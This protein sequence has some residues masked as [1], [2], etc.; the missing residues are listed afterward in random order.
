MSEI[1]KI[2][3]DV[4]QE[5]KRVIV[6]GDR[7]REPNSGSYFISYLGNESLILIKISEH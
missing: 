1:L 6:M 5:L 2:N 7:E 4:T 3:S